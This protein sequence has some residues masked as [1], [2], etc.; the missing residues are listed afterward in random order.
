MSSAAS[1]KTLSS[2]LIFWSGQI[3]S[4]LGSTIVLFV[5]IWWVVVEYSSPIYLSIAYLVG[6][7][8]QVLFMPIAGVF[9]DRWN[10]KIILGVAETLQI[11]GALVLILLF[12]IQTKFNPFDSLRLLL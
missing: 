1:R 12:S 7:G 10:R 9:V 2:Y 6:I 5:L 3:L 11:I 4:L 8:V